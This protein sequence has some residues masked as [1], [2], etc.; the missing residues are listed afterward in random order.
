MKS[1]V[2]KLFS[3]A[4]IIALSASV[5]MAQNTESK[6]QPPNYTVIDLGTPLGGFFAIGQSINI[7]GWVGG[8]G[9][10]NYPNNPGQNQHAIQWRTSSKA[11]DLGTLGGPNSALY[12]TYSGFSETSNTDPLGQDFCEYGDFLICL[13]FVLKGKSLV[14]LPTLGGDSAVAF[15]NN[16]VGQ[17]VGTSQTSTLDPSCLVDGLPQPPSYDVQGHLPAV[18]EN[19]QVKALPLLRGDSAGQADGVN[20]LGQVVGQAGYCLYTQVHA[21]LWKYGKV[22]NLGTLGGAM[23]NV[24]GAINNFGVVT[25]NSGL[26]GDATYHAFIWRNGIMTDL[27]T[28]PGDYSSYGQAINDLD[29]IVGGSCDINGNCRPF[30]WENGTMTD[31]NTL[32]PANSNL[33]LLYAN[34]INDFGEI[35]GYAFDQTT[36]NLPAFL[37]VVNHH[38]AADAP[39]TAPLSANAKITLPDSVRTALQQQLKRGRLGV[40]FTQPK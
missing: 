1:K 28:L 15:T 20:D 30:L 10:L 29:Q 23:N 32:I 34:T 6:N 27:G 40:R 9:N 24:G 12:G 22:I 36:G 33:Y 5:G 38:A 17:A 14:P 19:G 8:Y 35:V 16:N 37:A 3:I 31:L 21:L 26:S 7:L 4:G 13:P 2:L 39:P 25:G 18:W 11:I